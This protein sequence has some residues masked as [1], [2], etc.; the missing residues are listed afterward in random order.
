MMVHH[1]CCMMLSGVV[2]GVGVDEFIS[3][4]KVGRFPNYS[5]FVGSDVVDLKIAFKSELGH[6]QIVEIT[7]MTAVGEKNALG[8]I[9]STAI[10]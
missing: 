6:V 8:V 4:I 3:V 1:E 7:Q 9:T 10:T 2:V 5:I